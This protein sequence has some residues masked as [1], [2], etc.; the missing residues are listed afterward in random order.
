MDGL[1]GLLIL[2]LLALV[3]GAMLGYVAFARVNALRKRVDAL[4]DEL[5]A[6]KPSQSPQAFSQPVID[7]NKAHEE[8]WIQAPPEPEVMSETVAVTPSEPDFID[9]LQQNLIDN[10][11]I[12]LGGISVA[13]AGIFMVKYSINMGLLGPKAQI[14]MAIVTGLVLHAVAEW[15]R[16]R[17]GTS[18]PVFAALAGGASITLYAALLAALHLYHLIEPGWTFVFLSV[19]SLMTMLLAL[20]HGPML[21]MIGLVGAYVV[22][23]LVST[24]SGNIFVAMVYSLIISASG[25]FLLRYV[26]KTWLWWSVL[27]GGLGWWL[28]SLSSTQ[29]QDFRGLYLAI[30]GWMLLAV[31]SLDWLLQ[32]KAKHLFTLADRKVISTT[33]GSISMNQLGLV[34]I[35]LAW[36]LSIVWQGQSAVSFALWVPLVLVSC[37]AAAGRDSLKGLA[38]FSLF[39]QWIAWYLVGASGSKHAEVFQIMPLSEAVQTPF[40]IFAALMAFTYSAAS[41]WQWFTKGFSHL[42]VS[43]L[44]MSPLVW[45]A[46][47]Y[48]LVNGLEQSLNWSVA[49]LLA[50]LLYGLVSALRIERD[51]RDD[52][53]LWTI[54][55]AHFAYSLAVALYFREAS[56]S[57]ALAA[58][59]ISLCWLIKRYQL[60]WLEW[61]VKAVLTVV[62]I[63][64]TLNPW[65]AEYPVDI[66]WSLWV[67]GGSTLF[68]FLAS[69]YSN[70]GSN[71]R[72]WL[73][74]ATLHLL[75]MTLGAELR[76]WLYDGRIFIHRYDLVEA[77]INTSLWSGLALTYFYRARFSQELEKLYHLCSRVLLGMALVSYGIAVVDHN[78][79]WSGELISAT[80]ILNIL[81]LAYG[82]P[83]SWAVLVAYFHEPALRQ[84]ALRFAGVATLLFVSLEIRQLWQGADLSLDKFTGD[85]ELYTYSVVW[86]L[87]AIAGVLAGTRWQFKQLYKAGMALL[88]VVIA[89]IF[90]VDMSGLDGLWRVAAFMGLG[91]AMLA[92]AWFYKRM[93]SQVNSDS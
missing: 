7:D 42:T 53:A 3:V 75:V 84:F 80:P 83:I 90:L 1:I 38:W 41:A 43:L 91:L 32:G 23:I 72:V 20:I 69:R 22:P 66:H 35:V 13:L 67:Y 71:L 60:K 14:S 39:V 44:V 49:T 76:Y 9:R 24:G 88:A 78:P 31:P 5:A 65:L 34:M 87:M 40:L 70:V 77:A 81:L 18:D 11:M 89:K 37:L 73:E 62:V 52:V 36:G 46:L 92:L 93:Q 82:A 17:Q 85:G 10:W 61:L 28:I 25:L 47:S 12:W 57:L 86:M 2:L 64:L 79:W 27:A 48:L 50:G 30:L 59:L 4:S 6:L 21:A 54:L 16:R 58:Q 45:L 29:P 56:L 33:I 19:V 51:N 26:S 15:L 55:A 63:R 68:A 8:S 74:A